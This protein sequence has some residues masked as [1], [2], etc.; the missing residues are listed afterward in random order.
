MGF[1]DS[2]KSGRHKVQ[3]VV[4][5]FTDTFEIQPSVDRQV[6]DNNTP[7]L[8]K[9]GVPTWGIRNFFAT[10]P[11]IGNLVDSSIEKANKFTDDTSQQYQNTK[12]LID[13]I[14]N[15]AMI[16]AI[17]P[18]DAENQVRTLS[19]Q[20]IDF[21][22]DKWQQYW[23]NWKWNF[24]DYEQLSSMADIVANEK[25]RR[26]EA[27]SPAIKRSISYL[28]DYSFTE[29]Q[30]GI[31]SAFMKDLVDKEIKDQLIEP[32][33]WSTS[34]SIFRS[35]QRLFQWE[36]LNAETLIN[37][38]L[39]NDIANDFAQ[40]VADSYTSIH[41]LEKEIN[42]NKSHGDD[43]Q[44]QEE[45][46]AK[47][48]DLV[49]KQK[50]WYIEYIKYV[51]PNIGTPGNQS[52]QELN[53]SF[54]KVKWKTVA[55]TLGMKQEFGWFKEFKWWKQVW[56]AQNI[57]NYSQEIQD[58]ALRNKALLNIKAL[59]YM[60]VDWWELVDAFKTVVN[61]VG[62]VSTYIT[63][64]LLEWWSEQIARWLAKE[65]IN[66]SSDFSKA[67][68]N[69]TREAIF[70]DIAKDTVL[71][72][73]VTWGAKILRNIQQVWPEVWWFLLEILSGEWIGKA[74]GTTLS[75]ASKL[76]KTLSEIP[77]WIRAISNVAKVLTETGSIKDATRLVPKNLPWFVQ[78][79][80]SWMRTSIINGPIAS[81][82]FEQYNPQW[83]SKSDFLIDFLFAGSDAVTEAWRA[84]RFLTKTHSFS[85]IVSDPKLREET[86]KR[87]TFDKSN[88][89]EYARQV[90][91]YNKSPQEF[92]NQA[93]ARGKQIVD[94]TTKANTIMP[95][96]MKPIFDDIY[97]IQKIRAG[98]TI[99]S[100]I[101]PFSFL[102]GVVKQI[103]K[104]Q[105][106]KTIQDQINKKVKYIAEMANGWR[107][108]IVNLAAIPDNQWL[109][110]IDITKKAYIPVHTDVVATPWSKP[111]SIATIIDANW[112]K[113]PA[114][115][116]GSLVVKR[117]EQGSQRFAQ[118][119][120]DF[121]HASNYERWPWGPELR[122]KR[123]Y[124]PSEEYAKQIKEE[125]NGLEISFDSDYF[126]FL[127]EKDVEKW[128][129]EMKNIKWLEGLDDVVEFDKWYKFEKITWNPLDDL[130]LNAYVNFDRHLLWVSS[131][132]WWK[133]IALKEAIIER[134]LWV[135]TWII[136]VKPVL[137]SVNA[138]KNAW[139][140]DDIDRGD[141]STLMDNFY[142]IGGVIKEYLNGI[143][144]AISSSIFE[145]NSMDH[146]ALKYVFDILSSGKK[147]II[148]AIAK[149]DFITVMADFL[150]TDSF[151][152]RLILGE[153]KNN[154]LDPMAREWLRA[155]TNSDGTRMF[156][157]QEI[158]DIGDGWLR[159]RLGDELFKEVVGLAPDVN[160][161]VRIKMYN[162]FVEKYWDSFPR[163]DVLKMLNIFFKSDNNVKALEAV[164]KSTID[165]KLK[166]LVAT[167]ISESEIKKE[168][169]V[170]I[171]KFI[172]PVAKIKSVYD[173]IGEIDKIKKTIAS[174]EGGLAKWRR[175]IK[176]WSWKKETQEWWIAKEKDSLAKAEKTLIED[177]N[178]DW[179]KY[180]EEN[181]SSPLIEKKRDYLT[182]LGVYSPDYVDD[183]AMSIVQ[184]Y[185]GKWLVLD[186]LTS[187]ITIPWDP[188]AQHALQNLVTKAL[189]K[190]KSFSE[191][192]KIIAKK[193]PETSVIMWFLKSTFPDIKTD[194]MN[195][196]LLLIDAQVVAPSE[197]L[198]DSSIR[199]I[200]EALGGAKLEKT[201]PS[202][203]EIIA[204][205]ALVNIEPKILELSSHNANAIDIQLS[206]LEPPI[207]EDIRAI[208]KKQV[209]AV[210][211]KGG[212]SGEVDQW[213][214]DVIERNL[215]GYNV[216]YGGKEAFSEIKDIAQEAKSEVAK[217]AL[218]ILDYTKQFKDT[219]EPS[220]EKTIELIADW[221]RQTAL[222]DLMPSEIKQYQS[223][224]PVIL[225]DS[226]IN[227]ASFYLSIQNILES[228]DWVKI[229]E[230][231]TDINQ[232]SQRY[233]TKEAQYYVWF[234]NQLAKMMP[235]F[236]D[237]FKSRANSVDI[238]FLNKFIKWLDTGP[239]ILELV[240]IS[241]R[242]FYWSF[243]NDKD[244]FEK[245]FEV[246]VENF[247][248]VK[249]ALQTLGKSDTWFRTFN[250][251][252]SPFRTLYRLGASVT[253]FP[254]ILATNSLSYYTSTRSG[255]RFSSRADSEIANL[256]KNYG[257][258]YN[259]YND[260]PADGSLLDQM[261]SYW[262]RIS[263]GAKDI[264]S[265]WA[266]NI[267][268]TVN[269][270]NFAN[271][272]MRN[273]LYERWYHSPQELEMSLSMLSDSDRLLELG[274]LNQA[275]ADSFYNKMWWAF[276]YSEWVFIFGGSASS[277]PKSKFV[278]KYID[279]K[280]ILQDTSIRKQYF[281]I[282]ADK[283][284]EAAD[285]FIRGI[286][287]NWIDSEIVPSWI[288]IWDTPSVAYSMIMNTR[289]FMSWW[290][291]KHI[292][293]WLNHFSALG[294]D[295]VNI[296]QWGVREKYY[297]LL[298]EVWIDAANSYIR[299]YTTKHLDALMF[300]Q[301]ILQSLYTGARINRVLSN[302]DSGFDFDSPFSEALDVI[303]T[304]KIFF[305]PLQAMESSAPGRAI[306]AVLQWILMDS[307]PYDSNVNNISAAGYL[308]FKQVMRDL[309]RQFAVPGAIFQA[310]NPDAEGNFLENL[311]RAYKSSVSGVLN[312]M[313]DEVIRDWFDIP[314]P[315]T[316][317]SILD[318]IIP[319][320]GKRKQ[321]YY[322]M[323]TEKQ[324]KLIQAGD[325]QALQNRI[326][327]S[328]PL[329]KNYKLWS[330]VNGR[331]FEDIISRAANDP[332]YLDYL[333]GII[334]I[335]NDDD[336]ARY[337][338]NIISNRG[339]QSANTV[340]E[341]YGDFRVKYMSKEGKII[342]QL[343]SRWDAF[344]AMMLWYLSKWQVDE[345]MAEF[346]ANVVPKTRQW[347][348]LLAFVQ[349]M[350]DATWSPGASSYLLSSIV[351]QEY[352]DASK[353]LKKKYGRKWDADLPE[354]LDRQ[355]KSNIAKRYAD[356][357]FLVD[358]E[359]YAQVWMYY[360][361]KT[362]PDR[363]EL[364][365]ETE[366]DYLP[367]QFATSS[368][369]DKKT[370][371]HKDFGSAKANQQ[372]IM[373]TFVKLKVAEWK[374]DSYSM[375]NA[376]SSIRTPNST[377]AKNPIYV[378]TAMQW[379]KD[380]ISYINQS[381]L[382]KQD[383]IS[384]IAGL[385]VGAMPILDKMVKDESF[386]ASVGTDHFNDLMYWIYGNSKDIAELG[387]NLAYRILQDGNYNRPLEKTGTLLDNYSETWNYRGD[388]YS[389]N[390][391]SDY[392]H[393]RSSY[394]KVAWFTR[395]ALKVTSNK[396]IKPVSVKIPDYTK[397][398]RNLLKA[399][400]NIYYVWE[401]VK[402]TTGRRRVSK[403]KLPKWTKAKRIKSTQW[404]GRGS[405][406]FVA[407]NKWK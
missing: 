396:F 172:E 11:I 49:E 275:A 137:W 281:W 214:V 206:N 22:K 257:I 32:G 243:V 240:K 337:V 321:D 284:Q 116:P 397:S 207:P 313:S 330:F 308:L 101:A 20:F 95:A 343:Q 157:D 357:L 319:W 132:D 30:I 211:K 161:L 249:Q 310:A 115:F 168:N 234:M 181:P 107:I 380:S 400:A 24:A 35:W 212:P 156:T 213:V 402:W 204:K 59:K 21:A 192:E 298:Q 17:S 225:S 6:F 258:L 374:V 295:I 76:P 2:L 28:W 60:W 348:Q 65:W 231:L 332:V 86:Y 98:E 322:K 242:K 247:W 224:L 159:A 139:F 398:E 339:V 87:F 80:V 366:W 259:A 316:N 326:I 314:M 356:T 148:D 56:E 189:L 7:F 226:K 311:F 383:K 270:W 312:M 382:S 78:S 182:S 345:F 88:P 57:V 241:D 290:G 129:S 289:M 33:K 187:V 367:I 188:M 399:K 268:E 171:V 167:K 44:A 160:D 271:S 3:D 325:K 155:L 293:N 202:T 158:S 381:T 36:P 165:E 66:V 126:D 180:M 404:R 384:A 327:Y 336:Y 216:S 43:T 170:S 265:M 174:L 263:K 46:L 77:T 362:N 375:R 64:Y 368:G 363:Q 143:N 91:D 210:I 331:S 186:K 83:Y 232:F 9:I 14:S 53:E 376:F 264:L 106:S 282:K 153:W 123:W 67:D 379:L 111:Y 69:S 297:Q 166:S 391:Q 145:Q 146:I 229:N 108:D 394:N 347:L 349:T 179:K 109:S 73:D 58:I 150:R 131:D 48:K 354:E 285:A 55:E 238:E 389:S 329:L 25:T 230:L 39:T 246:N 37:G 269:A 50:Q 42:Y 317:K 266:Y 250:A 364:F 233:K 302:K 303:N 260:V 99:A 118:L 280:D 61:S 405:R 164:E 279:Y 300:L 63:K 62:A 12:E 223:L 283:W 235:K 371:E 198:V 244:T 351:T 292:K 154:L 81:G 130:L 124:S 195:K 255:K 359:K 252:M 142:V 220:I 340:D 26:L 38:K 141:I 395:N 288:E 34:S 346:K 72:I 104:P 96:Q 183:Y 344:T 239:S 45:A 191:I 236:S 31:Q 151:I 74:V 194:L 377:E 117:W 328:I 217:R 140:F 173:Q 40:Q 16:G 184:V 112:K 286:N 119:V 175:M 54:A 208:I 261:K 127:S 122:A 162:N 144:K 135:Y 23:I 121:F 120:Q 307:E 178:F 92:K 305:G 387:Q 90:A 149:R 218:A 100:G 274:K 407:S 278:N 361:R 237:V 393:N 169:A 41:S 342:Q 401:L 136:D 388:Y 341:R 221:S 385:V 294:G 103:S 219:I 199:I 18:A 353:K 125:Y 406:V 262:K 324:I 287:A 306:L 52:I 190:W 10:T 338:Y 113:S 134:W 267:I 71:W 222:A 227:G 291:T 51:I 315:K 301:N 152:S 177:P 19:K 128:L 358:K 5:T 370:G 79:M 1:L 318:D 110:A 296:A 386:K 320:Y 75:A 369:I 70:W 253:A 335:E 13:Q 334:P 133:Y 378:R 390:S 373:D 323:S 15:K 273:A 276:N 163:D 84:R 196:K 97:R 203:E 85:E 251:I 176:V 29:D 68:M 272:A 8:E 277:N 82:I 392:L 114:F 27:L 360:L 209:S 254:Y 193:I 299:E 256:R 94:Y 215:D 201:Q 102:D 147:N 89:E 200:D 197:I 185:R 228:G 352:Y 205:E 403:L 350:E 309:G 138:L 105:D 365:S 304:G 4:Q 355:V 372:Y 93:I 245:L 333:N 47:A 248:K